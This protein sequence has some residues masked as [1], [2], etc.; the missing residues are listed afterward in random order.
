MSYGDKYGAG[1]LVAKDFTVPRTLVIES[2]SVK[3]FDGESKL[4]LRFVG[5]SRKLSC[6][7]TNAMVLATAFGDDEDVLPG[8]SITLYSTLVS[9]KGR[10][11]PGIRIRVPEQSET[12]PA[13]SGASQPVCTQTQAMWLYYSANQGLDKADLRTAWDTDC[14]LYFGGRPVASVTVEEWA[15]FVADGYVRKSAPAADDAPF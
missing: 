12:A 5:E 10:Q 3:T 13:V 4:V 6:N 2:A 14:R 8:L 1:Y 11:V 9:Y 7:K 15:Q